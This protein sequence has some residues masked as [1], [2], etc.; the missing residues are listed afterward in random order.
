MAIGGQRPS[1]SRLNH[2]T[3][4]CICIWEGDGSSLCQ[5]TDCPDRGLSWLTSGS[6]EKCLDNEGLN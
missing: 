2:G 5:D 3:A 4:L 1:T 6:P